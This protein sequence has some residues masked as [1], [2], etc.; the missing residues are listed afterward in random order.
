MNMPC[1][2]IARR[3]CSDIINV[4]REIV[5]EI[6]NNVKDKKQNRKNFKV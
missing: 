5:E 2:C 1:L 6:G 3:H 4:Y